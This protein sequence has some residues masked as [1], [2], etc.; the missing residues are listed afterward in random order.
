MQGAFGTVLFVVVA[1]TAVVALIAFLGA[2][3]V[4]EQIGR[5]GLSIGDDADGRPRA[6]E[7]TSAAGLAERDDEI[8]QLLGARNE[9]RV[10]R[11]EAELD[12]EVELQ[13]LT[14]PAVDPALREEVRSLVIARNERREGRGQPPLDV[15]AEV[16]RQLR[17]LGA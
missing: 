8:R 9:R 10:R 13:R 11:G 12:V 17:D 5:G 4:Y 7:P 1:V 6:P 3:K 2:G 14:A 16:D 15:E